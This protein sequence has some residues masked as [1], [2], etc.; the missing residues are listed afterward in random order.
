MADLFPL[1]LLSAYFLQS[2]ESQPHF[3]QEKLVT[4]A[5]QVEEVNI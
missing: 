5:N 1:S 4:F 3:F 2:K